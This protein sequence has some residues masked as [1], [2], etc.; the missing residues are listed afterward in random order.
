MTYRKPYDKDFPV[1]SEFNLERKHPVTG[2]VRPHRGIDIGLP[3]GTLIYAPLGGKVTIKT[4]LKDGVMTGYGNY[5][6]LNSVDALKRDVMF[7]FAHLSAFLVETSQNVIAGQ[8]LGRSGNT[9]TGSGP[10]LHFEVRIW[11]NEKNDFIAQ[12]P[13]EFFD[14][15]DTEQPAAPSIA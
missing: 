2:I 6:V 10:H 9:G 13:R 11:D 1:T 8:A 5:V 4:Q 7:I 14:F 3:E 15:G 12:N